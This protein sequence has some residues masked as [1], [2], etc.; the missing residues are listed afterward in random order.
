MMHATTN[1]K[2]LVHKVILKPIWTYDIQLW[3]YAS[4]SNLEILERFQ[5]KVLRIITDEPKYVPNAVIKRDLQVLTVRQAV[6]NCSVTYGQRL[7]D[8]PNSLAKSLF[9]RT[10]YIRSLKRH[11]PAD[12][13]TRF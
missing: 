8:N 12:L 13:G 11:Y 4:N 10:N 3:G 1:I 6:R 5:S 9:Q 2:L 7:D